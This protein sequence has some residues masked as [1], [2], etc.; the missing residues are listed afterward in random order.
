MGILIEKFR[1][2]MADQFCDFPFMLLRLEILPARSFQNTAR[3]CLFCK[4]QSPVAD[5]CRQQPR[6]PTQHPRI[7]QPYETYE[8]HAESCPVQEPYL[9]WQKL[10]AYLYPAR[11]RPILLA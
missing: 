4:L 7:S 5:R 8:A 9:A 3:I 11:C 1:S 6:I 2:G 10:K